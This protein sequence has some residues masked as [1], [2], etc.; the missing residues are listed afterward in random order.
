MVPV[1]GK[2]SVQGSTRL[3]L[4]LRFHSSPAERVASEAFAEDT[5]A[6]CSLETWSGIGEAHHGAKLK[7]L[8]FNAFYTC[9]SNTNEFEDTYGK[10]LGSS[11]TDP[12]KRVCSFALMDVWQ[13]TF[14]MPCTRLL[15][16]QSWLLPT[17]SKSILLVFIPNAR[18]ACSS[19]SAHRLC[20]NHLLCFSPGTATLLPREQDFLPSNSLL[21]YTEL[22]R[23]VTGTWWTI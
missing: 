6:L 16:L 13:F 2:I 22:D 18:V 17:I 21:I 23:L 15:L 5:C 9:N 7:L 19:A 1:T 3:K 12:A 4:T 14:M 20:L 8:L 11:T 10:E